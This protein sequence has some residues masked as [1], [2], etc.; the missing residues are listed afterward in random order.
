MITEGFGKLVAINIPGENLEIRWPI[1][2]QGEKSIWLKYSLV[3]QT[4]L[5]A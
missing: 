1:K 4:P 2:K 3:L 5:A